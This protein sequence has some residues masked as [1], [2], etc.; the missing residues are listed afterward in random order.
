VG[1]N[2]YVIISSAEIA[3]QA[4]EGSDIEVNRDKCKYTE[5]DLERN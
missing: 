2:I 4:G 3:L 1:E 5:P